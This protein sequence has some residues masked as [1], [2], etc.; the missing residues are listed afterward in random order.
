MHNSFYGSTGPHIFAHI[1]FQTQIHQKH[2][3][4]GALHRL[5]DANSICIEQPASAILL[6]KD[7][8]IPFMIFPTRTILNISKYSS[9]SVSCTRILNAL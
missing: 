3:P 2:W 1:W 5:K 7:P 4:N 8:T 9:V 6:T